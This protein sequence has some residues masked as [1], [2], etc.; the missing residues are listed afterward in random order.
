MLACIGPAIYIPQEKRNITI[1]EDDGTELLDILRDLRYLRA[2][3]IMSSSS[4]ND[5]N[6]LQPPRE[7][8]W[9]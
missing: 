3:E 1:V 7:L 4:Y 6:C 2:Q 5:G 8:A 9:I